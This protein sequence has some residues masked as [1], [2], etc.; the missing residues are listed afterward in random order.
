[1]LYFRH[2]LFAKKSYLLLLLALILQGCVST[3]PSPSEQIIGAWTSVIGGIETVST[4]TEST[5][6]LD[7]NPGLPYVLEG[8][9]L[10]VNGDRNTRRMVSFPSETEMVQLNPI[11]GT[12]HRFTRS[13]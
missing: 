8:S 6:S 4:Y 1:M 11:T 10:V 12:Q 9:E 2:M 13:P 7:N 3:A 5:V